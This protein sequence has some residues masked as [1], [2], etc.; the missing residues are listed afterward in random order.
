MNAASTAALLERIET[1]QTTF[2]APE[3]RL[4][5]YVLITGHRDPA[6]NATRRVK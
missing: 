2:R 4:G 1:L 5:W 6:S 3:H